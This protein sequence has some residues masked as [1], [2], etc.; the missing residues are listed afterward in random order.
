[1]TIETIDKTIDDKPS[2]RRG[3]SYKT[4]ELDGQVVALAKYDARTGYF[5]ATANNKPC[6]VFWHE[7]KAKCL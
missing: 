3:D 7:L 6:R 4:A 5:T 1:M 2:Q